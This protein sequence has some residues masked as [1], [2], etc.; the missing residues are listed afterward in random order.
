[1]DHQSGQGFDSDDSDLDMQAEISDKHEKVD[2]FS[3]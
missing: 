3:I 1:M 2:E